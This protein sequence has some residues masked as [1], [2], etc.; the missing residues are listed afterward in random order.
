MAAILTLFCYLVSVIFSALAQAENQF[1]YNGFDGAY[2]TMDHLAMIRSDGMLQ[3][4]NTSSL[5]MGHAFHPQPFKFYSSFSFST[6][7]VFDIV[8]GENGGGQGFAFVIAPSTDFSQAQKTQYLGLFNSTSNGLSTNHVLAIEFDTVPSAE[9][10]MINDNH[11]GIDINSLNSSYSATPSYFSEKKKKNE[12]LKLSG[13]PIQ[14]WID[15][16]DAK[17]LLDV[18]LAPFESQKPHQS[19]LSSHINIS[20]IFLDTMYVGFSASTGTRTSDHLILGWSFNTS[21][22][23]QT[24]KSSDLPKLPQHESNTKLIVGIS[25]LTAF[26]VLLLILTG[27]TYLYRR[28]YREL[29][30][31]WEETFG[32]QTFSYKHLYKATKGF[33]ETELLGAGGFG[34]VFKGTLRSNQQIAVKRVSHDIKHGMKQF[35]SEIVSMRRLRHKNLVQLLGYCRRKGELLLVYEYMPNGSLDDFLFTKNRPNLSWSQRFQIIKGVASAL[36]YLHEEWEQ[37]VLHRDIKASN[38]LLDAN[39]NGRLGDFGLARLYDRGSHLETTQLV[40]TPGYLAPELTRTNKATVSSDV[41]GF[42]VFLL[43]V[44]CGRRPIELRGLHEER[45]LI[46]WVI[47]CWRRNTLLKVVDL[48]LDGSYVV[49]EV[50]LILKLGLLCTHCVPDF[51]P[52]MGQVIQYLDGNVELPD[53]QPL[54]TMTHQG[55][56]LPSS[57]LS[58]HDNITRSPILSSSNLS[59]HDNITRLSGKESSS[60]SVTSITVSLGSIGR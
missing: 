50:E 35:V 41:F 52:G 22:K 49:E 31:E 16:D 57:N 6:Y 5:D 36:L 12:T 32:P 58:S 30:E 56:C 24:L 19:L 33:S 21:G 10:D 13:N 38:V 42:G 47:S 1:V 2:L 54:L 40:G 8:P 3:L 34:E 14:V 45:F 25:F 23:A 20:D 60:P 59:S 15:Y 55:L 43:E 28:K 7:F 51:R 29:R 53:I 44:A 26:V 4:T 18:T 11:V 9:F 46:D 37:V 17:M 39:L 48:R 27:A